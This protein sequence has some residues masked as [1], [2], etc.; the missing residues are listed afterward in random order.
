[1]TVSI[2]HMW[3]LEMTSLQQNKGGVQEAKEMEIPQGAGHLQSVSFVSYGRAAPG[4]SA[5]Y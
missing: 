2:V 4:D 3:N 1:M 5:A